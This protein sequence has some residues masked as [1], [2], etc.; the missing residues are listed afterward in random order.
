MRVHPLIYTCLLIVLSTSTTSVHAHFSV[1]KADTHKS[2]YGIGEIKAGPCGREDGERGSNIYT[3]APGETFTLS[4]VEF[5]GHPGFYRIAFDDDGDDDFKDPA[6]IIPAGRSC[7]AG[8]TYCGTN[9]FYNNK[10]VLIDDFG[11]HE[12]APHGKRYSVD[13]T[14]PEKECDNCTLQIIQIM[15][16]ASKAPYDPSASGADDLYYQCVDLVLKKD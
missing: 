2:R 1:E 15:S 6:S 3:Y 8:E 11:R 5:V 9:D 4:W 7:T 14:L 16:E 10:T 13:V 12:D